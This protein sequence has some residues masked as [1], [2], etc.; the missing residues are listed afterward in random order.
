MTRHGY[1]D[2]ADGSRFIVRGLRSGVAVR[3]GAW[4]SMPGLPG[5]VG[6]GMPPA[7]GPCCME[8]GGASARHGEIPGH[9]DWRVAAVPSPAQTGDVAARSSLRRASS[10][11]QLVRLPPDAAAI[12]C[13]ATRRQT[14]AAMQGGKTT[15]ERLDRQMETAAAPRPAPQGQGPSARAARAL[16]PPAG[17]RRAGGVRRGEHQDVQAFHPAQQRQHEA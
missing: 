10:P 1:P 8:T 2:R 5:P 17:V 11:G 12:G 3:P 16:A 4:G 7:F 9:G 13:E 15:R 14:E 6:P